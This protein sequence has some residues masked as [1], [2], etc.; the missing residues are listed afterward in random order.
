MQTMTETPIYDAVAS[1]QEWTPD[2]LRPPLDIGV[3]VS[4]SYAVVQQRQ[5]TRHQL[6]RKIAARQRARRNRRPRR[7]PLP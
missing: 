4:Q 6:R 7:N 1:E 2:L 3:L 5:L